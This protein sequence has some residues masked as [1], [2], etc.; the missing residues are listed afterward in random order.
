MWRSLHGG[1][2][3]EAA[4]ASRPRGAQRQ[5]LPL[6]PP[7]PQRHL[8]VQ[9]RIVH[10]NIIA[11]HPVS[12]VNQTCELIISLQATLEERSRA[13]W[14]VESGDGWHALAD[15]AAVQQAV[16]HL[17]SACCRISSAP[18]AAAGA[19]KAAVG[20]C[21]SGP[22]GG[23]PDS[24]PLSARLPMPLSSSK[25]TNAGHATCAKDFVM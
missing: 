3:F 5:L 1:V 4:D 19:E 13:Q 24:A 15:V 18:S 12:S 23:D 22:R 17:R 11:L 25:P 20:P 8:P 14:N 16:I 6:L 2:H 21:C 9:I 7:P 10:S